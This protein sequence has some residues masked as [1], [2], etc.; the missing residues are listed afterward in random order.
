MISISADVGGS[1]TDIILADG[2]NQKI[3]A[4]KVLSTPGSSQAIINGIV[5]ICDKA[6]LAPSAIDV[7]VHGFTIAT[8]AWLTRSGA[9]A[10]LAVTQGFRDVLEIGTQRRLFPYSLQSAKP[11][12]LVPTSHV[13]QVNERLDAFGGVVQPFTA[14]DAKAVAQRICALDPQAV[15]ISFLFSYLNPQHENLLE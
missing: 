4:E 3:Y 11:A 9:R 12:P 8:N 13:V 14:D 6:G 5:Q 15:A 10:A 1:F 2:R 7:F